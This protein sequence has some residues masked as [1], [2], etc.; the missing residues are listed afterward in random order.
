MQCYHF[1]FRFSRPSKPQ[2]TAQVISEMQDWKKMLVYWDPES[3]LP[4]QVNRR[5]ND[6]AKW[7]AVNWFAFISRNGGSSRL[8][9]SWTI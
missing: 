1:D 3:T 8:Q 6:H 2:Y 4:D 7:H 5:W 9:M